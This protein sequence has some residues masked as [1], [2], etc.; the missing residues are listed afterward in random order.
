VPADGGVRA[1]NQQRLYVDRV[2]GRS[3]APV[4]ARGFP[5]VVPVPRGPQRAA[6]RYGVA[7]PA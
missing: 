7:R 2:A 4:A 3:S 6:E 5:P 1:R